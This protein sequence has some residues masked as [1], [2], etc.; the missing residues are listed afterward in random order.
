MRQIVRKIATGYI[1]DPLMS[2]NRG[3]PQT[4]DGWIMQEGVVPE[5]ISIT[6]EGLVIGALRGKPYTC[7][8]D[9]GENWYE[10]D[11]LPNSEYQPMCDLLPDGRFI[12]VWHE[13]SDNSFGEADMTIGVHCFKVDASSVPDPAKLVLGRALSEANDQYI[14]VFTAELTSNGKPVSGESIELCVK[15]VWLPDRRQNPIDVSES[16]DVRTELTDE[17]GIAGFEL[18]DKDQIPDIHASYWVMPSYTPPKKSPYAACIGGQYM[19][20]P[21]TP[22]RNQPGHLDVFMEHG[23]IL[24]TPHIAEKYPDL[25]DVIAKLDPNQ[26]DETLDVWTQ[27]AGSEQRAQELLDLLERHHMLQCAAEGVYRWYRWVIKDGYPVIGEVRITEN[28]DNAK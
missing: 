7:S 13:G 27:H 22:V 16:D 3:A 12:N 8:K 1:N 23:N 2:I 15:P 17:N 24:V 5:A 20:Y 18:K 10:I 26:P 9:L 14:N 25:A 28:K 11:G 21:T 19:A 4:E 6:K